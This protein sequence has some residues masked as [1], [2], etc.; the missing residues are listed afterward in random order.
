MTN[1][2]RC[3][4]RNCLSLARWTSDISAIPC[5]HLHLPPTFYFK[6]GNWSTACKDKKKSVESVRLKKKKLFFLRAWQGGWAKWWSRWWLWWLVCQ[7]KNTVS[8]LDFFLRYCAAYEATWSYFWKSSHCDAPSRR[9]KD[10]EHP[11]LMIDI[12]HFR[13][14]KTLPVSRSLN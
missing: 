12:R 11:V 2:K 6:E 13:H 7:F 10:G 5:L 8:V 14:Q 9:Y 1:G 3:P 4:S